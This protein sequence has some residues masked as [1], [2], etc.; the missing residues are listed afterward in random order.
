MPCCQVREEAEQMM[1]TASQEGE[2][3]QE[4]VESMQYTLC[5]LKVS[6]GF[7][8]TYLRF[9]APVL[10]CSAMTAQAD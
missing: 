1:K 4:A 9:L 7:W 8:V 2:P 10:C 3:Q 5:A 6:M